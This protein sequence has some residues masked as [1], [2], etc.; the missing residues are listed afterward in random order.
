MLRSTKFI[1]DA[2][3]KRDLLGLGLLAM[4]GGTILWSMTIVF[5]PTMRQMALERFHLAGNSF[6]L[7]AVHQAVP[8]MYNMENRIQFTNRLIGDKPFDPAD[9]SYIKRTLNHYPA[10]FITFGNNHPVCFSNQPQGT[11]EIRSVFGDTELVTRWEITPQSQHTNLDAD[12]KPDKT[13]GSTGGPSGS[14]PRT[15]I[16]RQISKKW[17]VTK[18][19]VGHE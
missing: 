11:F 17:N 14:V 8:A 5:S 4:I 16:V 13:A 10:R 3:A 7:W 12:K 18:P 19:G 2:F 6:P 1:P 15:M 9:E